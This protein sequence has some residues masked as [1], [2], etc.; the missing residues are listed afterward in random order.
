MPQ[1]ATLGFSLSS[2]VMPRHAAA[3]A[4]AEALRE[5]VAVKDGGRSPRIVQL[6]LARC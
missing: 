6:T 3:T 5:V 2:S 4:Y 1:I